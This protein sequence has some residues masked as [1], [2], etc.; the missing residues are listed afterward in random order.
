MDIFQIQSQ[1]SLNFD[2]FIE[3]YFGWSLKIR[4]S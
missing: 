2:L 1:T 3:N 4:G